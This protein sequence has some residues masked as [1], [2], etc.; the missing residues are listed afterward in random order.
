MHVYFVSGRPSPAACVLS[1]VVADAGG[2]GD[3]EADAVG[4]A[5]G[6]SELAATDAAVVAVVVAVAD[7]VLRVDGVDGVVVVIGVLVVGGLA[8]R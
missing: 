4:A 8:L 5:A 2:V 3:T 1:L 7:D 6:G